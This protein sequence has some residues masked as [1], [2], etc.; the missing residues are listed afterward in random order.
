LPDA[1]LDELAIGVRDCALAH[2]CAIVGGDTVSTPGP[3]A[4]T[5]TVVGATARPVLRRGARAGEAVV[6][7]GPF[8]AA[9]IGLAALRAG[10]D[11]EAA[12]RCGEAYRRPRARLADGA[13]LAPLA[14]AMIDVSDGLLQ[15]LGHLCEAG[16]VGADVDL[17]RVPLDDATRETA[18]RLGLDAVDAAAG[19]G[20]DYQ[21][22]ATV[23]PHD[24]PEL[25]RAL[26]DATV[27]GLMRAG[28]GVAATRR[29]KPYE[30]PRRGYEHGKTV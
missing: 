10:L 7:T 26:P 25:R 27:I 16:G 12:R 8:G 9:A 4:L 13:A 15:D 24:L 5:V 2:G 6:V 28:A 17:D 1:A 21:L 22:L 14:T 3:L 19:A 11:G 18:A 20:D 30:P 29:G 23:D